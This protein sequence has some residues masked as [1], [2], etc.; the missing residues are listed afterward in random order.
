MK[1][2]FEGLR[3]NQNDFRSKAHG[4]SQTW[5]YGVQTMDQ[6]DKVNWPKSAVTEFNLK[7]IFK[8]VPTR[9]HS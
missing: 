3:D 7:E 1:K 8:I 9:F 6:L 5:V 4:P 2:S